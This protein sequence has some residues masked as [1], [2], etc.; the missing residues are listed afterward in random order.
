MNSKIQNS[1]WDSRGSLEIK[2]L[3]YVASALETGKMKQYCVEI[4]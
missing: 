1:R 3:N 4:K 2:K